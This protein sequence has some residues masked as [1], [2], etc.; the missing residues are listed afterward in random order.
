[1]GRPPKISTNDR[2]QIRKRIKA[3]S[4]SKLSPELEAS[5]Q[6]IMRIRDE[7]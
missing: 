3:E 5:R 4:I 7:K 1:M 2:K 6:I